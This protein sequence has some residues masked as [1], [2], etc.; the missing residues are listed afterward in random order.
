MLVS[1]RGGGRTFS[2]AKWDVNQ[3]EGPDQSEAQRFAQ[4]HGQSTPIGGQFPEAR[5]TAFA[6][7]RDFLSAAQASLNSA[8]LDKGFHGARQA[9]GEPIVDNRQAQSIDA[10]LAASDS[11]P[12]LQYPDGPSDL[13]Q[14]RAEGMSAESAAA[15]DILIRSQ[16]RVAY[17]Y[18]GM[19]NRTTVFLT[20][21]QASEPMLVD[22]ILKF[23]PSFS[24]ISL[25][26]F[27]F[28]VRR[29]GFSIVYD[30]VEP[31]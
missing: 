7:D 24:P 15:L 23:V 5:L 19:E 12:S 22:R 16:L 10:L 20:V 1:P 14:F 4:E 13:A 28:S 11:K 25:A 2:L 6:F 3:G 26:D 27:R 17:Q 31:A 21:P 29:K 8:G 18:E 9:N 30:H